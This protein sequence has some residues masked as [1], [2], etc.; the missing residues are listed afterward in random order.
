MLE[1]YKNFWLGYIDFYGRTK[2]SDYWWVVLI[3]G[4]IGTL[5]FLLMDF[6]GETKV[7]GFT[8]TAFILFIAATALPTISMQ[9]RRLRDANFNV[10]WIVLKATPLLVVLWVMYAFP[11][12]N[13][14]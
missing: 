4:V 6:L 10:A 2:R 8:L 12:R 3:N 13:S 14:K 11:T 5:I 7:A 9:I 1:A